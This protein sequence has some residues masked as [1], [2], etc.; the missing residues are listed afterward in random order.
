MHV[1]HFP[2][3]KRHLVL[4][5]ATRPAMAHGVCITLLKA[6]ALLCHIQFE[7]SSDYVHSTGW[8]VKVMTVQLNASW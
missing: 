5:E 3:G 8:F 4:E 2:A 7:F 1:S 6:H